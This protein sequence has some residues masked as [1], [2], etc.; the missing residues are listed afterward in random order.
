[1]FISIKA[2]ILYLGKMVLPV[3][4]VPFYPYPKSVDF[5]SFKYLLPLVLVA[6]ITIAAVI[7]ARKK[8]RLWL[9]VWSVY[10]VMLLPVIGIMQVAGQEM[11]DRYTYLPSIGPF[12]LAG[13]G[14]SWLYKKSQRANRGAMKALSIGMASLAVLMLSYRTIVQIGI[15][16]DSLT[17][18]NY[19]IAKEPES[20]NAYNHRG[21]VYGMAGAY[22]KAL[23]DFRKSVVFEPND[24]RAHH[25]LGATYDRLGRYPEAFAEYSRA[26]ELRPDS[27]EATGNRA[28]LFLRA[29][30]VQSAMIDFQRSCAAG[31]MTSC[32]KLRELL[33]Q[34]ESQGR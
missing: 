17:L 34:M 22:E 2:V 7:Y 28:I 26:I 23:E 9:A 16:K 32:K 27:A 33:S 12:L 25:N 11:A 19:V 4:L 13:L 3:N 24:A 31:R 30:D 20:G 8:Q 10:V 15:W 1:L 5:L 14:A 6:G 18:W 21:L 29:G